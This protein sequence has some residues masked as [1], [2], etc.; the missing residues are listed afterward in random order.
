MPNYSFFDYETGFARKKIFRLSYNGIKKKRCGTN[1]K[2]DCHP[3]FAPSNSCCCNMAC[4]SVCFHTGSPMSGG[5]N[6]TTARFVSCQTFHWNT[7][8]WC[9][10]RCLTKSFWRR[11]VRRKRHSTT[12]PFWSKGVIW[13]SSLLEHYSPCSLSARTGKRLGF[14]Q[15]N[16]FTRFFKKHT[17][18]TPGEYRNSIGK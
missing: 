12:D 5:W 8:G 9:G 10:Y 6:P 13:F 17:G 1:N 16:S 3:C 18:M 2:S 4:K 15:F 11:R 7:I 14:K